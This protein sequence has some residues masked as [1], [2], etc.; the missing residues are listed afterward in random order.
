VGPLDEAAVFE[1]AEVASDGR[2]RD[3]EGGGEFVDRL[4]ALLGHP[5]DDLPFTLCG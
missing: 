5:L 2:F 4:A 1:V 3:V